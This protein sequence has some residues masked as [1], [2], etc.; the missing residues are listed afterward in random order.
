LGRLLQ[1]GDAVTHRDRGTPG[2]GLEQKG[3]ALGQRLFD[4]HDRRQ[5]LVLHLDQA[6]SAV[7]GFLVDR[8]DRRDHVADI[9]HLVDRDDRLV[10]DRDAVVRVRQ[11]YCVGA[12]YDRGDT[13][14]G[15]GAPDIDRADAGMRVGTAQNLGV[16]HAGQAEVEGVAGSTG[17]FVRSVERNDR[18]AERRRAAVHQPA[19]A[20]A[21]ARTA[22]TI[23]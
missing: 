22:S 2:R 20:L 12:G 6:E 14:Q 4:G 19:P 7:G 23:I 10:A 15:F 21:A 17:D 16:Q 13:G 1:A 18:R 5:R 8:R 3:G 9:A 11:P